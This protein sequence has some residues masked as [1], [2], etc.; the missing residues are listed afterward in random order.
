MPYMTGLAKPSAVIRSKLTTA[1][2]VYKHILVVG[3]ITTR[4]AV[5]VPCWFGSG[6]VL[7]LVVFASLTGH[8]LT[9]T[10][11]KIVQFVVWPALF[12]TIHVLFCIIN[13]PIA[14]ILFL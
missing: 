14:S 10:I 2:T 8:T 4:A 5:F 3:E 12:W 1:L 13:T 6:E 7:A 11:N 9:A